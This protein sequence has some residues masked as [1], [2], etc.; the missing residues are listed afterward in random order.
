MNSDLIQGQIQRER[1]GAL[2]GNITIPSIKSIKIP[3]PPLSTQK[4]IVKNYYEL[5][6]KTDEMRKKAEEIENKAKLEI[7][8]HL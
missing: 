1:I 2:Q 7:E 5:K 8:D 4:T 6:R 3:V